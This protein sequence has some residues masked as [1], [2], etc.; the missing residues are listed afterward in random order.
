MTQVATLPDSAEAR[1]AP[2]TVSVEAAASRLGIGRSLAYQLAREGWFPVPVIRA[3]R[4]IVVPVRALD[5]VL[6]ID[7]A[8]ALPRQSA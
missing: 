5:R 2:E 7:D 6:G 8:D 3:G 4:K 1:A